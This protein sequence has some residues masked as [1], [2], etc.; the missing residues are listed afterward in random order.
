M[1]IVMLPK[2]GRFLL[3]RLAH[4]LGGLGLDNL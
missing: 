2:R 3:R 1:L 4:D